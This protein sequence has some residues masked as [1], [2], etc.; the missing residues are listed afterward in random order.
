MLK[1]ITKKEYNKLKYSNFIKDIAE[2]ALDL[3]N[4]II[5]K[6]RIQIKT[7]KDI[8]DRLEKQLEEDK[9]IVNVY[10]LQVKP[11][12]K[13]EKGVKFSGTKKQLDKF[14]KRNSTKKA[15]KDH[16]NKFKK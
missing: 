10:K 3:A 1:I 2:F 12:L 9:S 11:N 5:D 4:S 13:K 16:E 7:L 6:Q 8:I 15:K 14:I